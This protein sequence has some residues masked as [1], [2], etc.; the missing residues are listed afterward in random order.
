MVAAEKHF[1]HRGSWPHI[2]KV[3]SNA[4]ANCSDERVTLWRPALQTR[5][6]QQFAFPVQ[7]YQTEPDDLSDAHAVDGEKQHD[8]MITHI[9]RMPCV[10]VF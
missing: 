10:E 1:R 8:R 5:H 4:V 3:A 9:G 7:V 2:A 6:A